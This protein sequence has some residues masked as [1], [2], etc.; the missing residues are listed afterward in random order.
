RQCRAGRAARSTRRG[1][2]LPR[3]ANPQPLQGFAPRRRL[4][5]RTYRHLDLDERRTL[6]RLVEAR[7]PVGE[8]ARR[9]SRQ[10]RGRDRPAARQPPFHQPPRAG[11]RPLPRRRPRLL[12]LLPPER[13]GPRPPTPTATSHAGG[14]RGVAHARDR[15]PEVP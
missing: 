3:S 9:P 7:P 2:V 15:A 4:L 8:I 12:R 6:F 10:P 5:A 11:P 13:P 1:W 14:R